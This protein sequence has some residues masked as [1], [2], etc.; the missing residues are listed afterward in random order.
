VSRLHRAPGGVIVLLSL[1]AA[2]SYGR[3][4][5]G[6][7]SSY[8]DRP[9]TCRGCHATLGPEDQV[10]LEDGTEL[11][12]YVGTNAIDHSV[13][14]DDLD[15]IDCHRAM[16]GYPHEPI[17]VPTERAYRH[18]MSKNCNGCHFELFDRLRDSMHFQQVREDNLDAA[19]CVD[20]HGHHEVE[21]PA[22]PR[23]EVSR[24]CAQCHEEVAEVY[25]DSIHGESLSDGSAHSPVCTDC[26]G[27]HAIQPS[28]NQK[29]HA[30]SYQICANCHGD[31]DIMAIYEI[32]PNVIDTYL[33]DF[34]GVSN[35]LYTKVG[36]VPE[37]PIAT[38]GDC[39][40]VHDVRE[41]GTEGGSEFLREHVAAMCEECHEGAGTSFAGAWMGHEDPSLQGSPLVWVVMW[42]YR[43][44]I[45]V[46]V[47]A[48]LIHIFMH[49]YRAAV[50]RA[51]TGGH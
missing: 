4:P 5:E 42:G 43:I 27:A 11:P 15:C 13:H 30:G 51:R 10:Q 16:R 35:Y 26:H 47:I 28:K 9:Q 50:E 32:N 31:P 41:I 14:A 25:A 33:D 18:E 7:T 49:F 37:R 23:D 12:T 39:H 38:C 40:G 20:C 45:P 1:A 36:H 2:D 22:E 6:E 17:R 46:M 44:L 8:E 24:R 3:A 21:S 29:F 19:T 34:H 48:L